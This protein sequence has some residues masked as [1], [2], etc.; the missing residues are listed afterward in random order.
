MIYTIEEKDGGV[1]KESTIKK[2]WETT[3][4]FTLSQVEGDILRLDKMA[5]EIT[6][7]RDLNS[8]K[9][10]NIETNNP[11][12][13]DIKEADMFTCHMYQEAKAVVVMANKK[14]K[15]IQEASLGLASE[16]EEI[17]KQIP[18]LAPVEIPLVEVVPEVVPEIL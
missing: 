3:A 8:A 2:V 1:N 13:L 7:Q 4:E 6:A 14:L 9:M 16:K 18:E 10:T 12:I 5:T 15:E 17:F 11:F